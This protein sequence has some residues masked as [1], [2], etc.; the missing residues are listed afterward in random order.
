MPLRLEPN[1]KVLYASCSLLTSHG[2]ACPL[3]RSYVA[4]GEVHECSSSVA[5]PAAVIRR[6][7]GK[8]S[9]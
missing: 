3:C 4:P 9:K 7:M 1:A 6:V 2:M 5:E 8:E